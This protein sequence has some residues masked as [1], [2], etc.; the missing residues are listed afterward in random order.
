MTLPH[1]IYGS[2]TGLGDYRILA[3]TAS[4]DDRLR[5]TIIY[6]ANL[7][8]SA[9]STPFAPIFSFYSVGEGLWAFSRTI[10][11][12]PTPRG[13]DYLVHAIVLDAAALARIE[14]KPF[15]LADA[16]VFASKKPPE[17]TVLQPISLE[18]VNPPSRAYPPDDGSIAACIRALAR[19]PLRLRMSD[20]AVD[21][22]REIH[23]SL[24]PDDRATTTFCT[25]FSY[26]RNLS[27]TLAA[28]SAED[29]SRVRDTAATATLTN[30]PPQGSSAPDLFDRW[31]KEIRGQADFDLVGL[32]VIRDAREAFA[33]VDGVRQLRLWTAH[34]KANVSGLEKASALV[35][36]K[37]N[38]GRAVVQGVL[39]GALAV[40]LAARVRR[41]EAF[42][43]CA[44]LCN[45][46][47]P[48]VRRASVQWIRELKTTPTEGWMAEMLLL[49]PDGSL[50]DVSEGLQRAQLQS[51]FVQS[52]SVFRAFVTTLLGRMRDRFGDDGASLAATATPALAGN[53]DVLLSFVR[54]ME[55][56][57]S[58]G[59]LLAI[60]RDVFTKA[61]IAPAIPARIILSSGLISTIS[62]AELETFGPAFFGLEEKLANA[63]AVTPAAE[64]PALYR[65]LANVAQARLREGWSPRSAAAAEVVR[66]VII[67]A[68]ETGAP[69]A[70][71][72]I[73]VALASTV[74][75]ARDLVQ[76]IELIAFAGITDAQAALLTRTLQSLAR[77]SDDVSVNRRALIVLLEAARRRPPQ[78]VWG[79]LSWYLRM[80]TLTEV[81]G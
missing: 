54:V 3:S 51:L 39:P 16:R 79:R 15:V 40:D 7:E 57:G 19:G 35:L 18:G 59:W 70:H 80:R 49:L 4:F 53:R 13:N 36:R 26:G 63:L 64:R 23:E 11:L 71:L 65:V 61:G 30:F 58:R 32:S 29:E 8:G 67:G 33:L 69:T 45:E 78:T 25:R 75:P 20:D 24:P 9:R 62:D 47:D 2:A 41:G 21:V 46:I 14:F 37:E 60:I 38:R 27:F 48:A 31:T 12:E 17:G 74:I 52:P 77:R 34:D 68:A 43:E 22:C 76:V 44:K 28:F 56:I 66:R 55:E 1:A 5:S 6:Y 42:D 81:V 50:A 73:I 10:C 72:T